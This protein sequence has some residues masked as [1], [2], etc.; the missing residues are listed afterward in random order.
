VERLKATLRRQTRGA[1][2][3]QR[4]VVQRLAI[5]SRLAPCLLPLSRVKLKLTRRRH[6]W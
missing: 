1:P 2:L 4:L 3:P 6:R 5:S